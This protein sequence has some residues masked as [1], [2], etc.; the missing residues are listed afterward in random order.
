MGMRTIV[1]VIS[2]FF[3][4]KGSYAEKNCSIKEYFFK[5][6]LNDSIIHIDLQIN[7]NSVNNNY[8]LFNSLIDKYNI[9]TN[10]SSFKY[11][12]RNDT[13][14]FQSSI[15]TLSLKINYSIT[16]RNKGF[17]DNAFVKSDSVQIF[18]E[19]YYKWYPLLYNNLSN[20]HLL[21][22]VPEEMH[23]FSYVSY[24]IVNTFNGTTS[25]TFNLFDED[26]PILISKRNIFDEYEKRKEGIDF[27]FYFNKG[28]KRLLK[29]ENG[30]PVFSTDSAD[31]DSINMILVN[32]CI[33]VFNWYNS[34]FWKKEL[35]SVNFIESSNSNM[36]GFGLNSLIYL[37]TKMINYD[38]YYK[39]QISHEIG[40]LWFGLNTK[41][42][43][44][45]RDFM[46]E[47]INEYVNLLYYKYNLG[48][49]LYNKL[50]ME[51]FITASSDYTCS[52]N[53]VLLAKKV[54]NNSVN[55]DVLIY[56]KGP[57]FLI[58]LGEKIGEDKMINI[59]RDTYNQRK[60]L[61]TISDFEKNIRKYK[62]WQEYQ[63]L[64]EIEL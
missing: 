42:D 43:T 60:K 55:P 37:T 49:T 5:I 22:E 11:I 25:Y 30:R 13:L 40:H 15:D 18:F 4:F 61:L 48:D 17:L 38:L 28:Q 52:F 16:W 56:L 35:K 27:N 14:Y 10:D 53:D 12:H 44:I 57:L 50:I 54:L 33:D 20:F 24:D 46:S 3:L 59:I 47:T 21:A 62:S 39:Y 29:V 2:F 45:G 23:V 7:L 9:E 6:D 8:L 58:K 1:L 26:I 51:Q 41:Y 34:I 32:R 36:G 31:I 63:S 19:R 64:F